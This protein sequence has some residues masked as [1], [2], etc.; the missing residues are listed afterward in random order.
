MRLSGFVSIGP[1]VS[2]TQARIIL[3]ITITFGVRWD[4]ARNRR[5]DATP[6]ARLPGSQVIASIAPKIPI[7]VHAS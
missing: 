5:S 2:T 6:A 3:D 1:G 7:A 4:L